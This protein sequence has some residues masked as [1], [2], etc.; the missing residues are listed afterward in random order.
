[1]PPAQPVKAIN[2]TLMWLIRVTV[3]VVCFA[4]GWYGMDWFLTRPRT[5]NSPTS[6]ISFTYPGKWKKVTGTGFGI[7]AAANTSGQ[8][9]AEV[10]LA[11]GNSETNANYYLAVGSS[12]GLTTDFET[13]KSR[14][15]ETDPS[16]LT[17]NMPSGSTV[18]GLT[19]TDTTIA[20]APAVS[21]KYTASFSGYT[22][23]C[24]V[25]FIQSG[26]TLYLLAFRAKKPKGTGE[27]FQELLRTVK[28]KT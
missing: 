12:K 20:G 9:T 23:D 18:T 21:M 7:A 22:S 8:M 16:V 1:M 11:D 15:R 17:A 24:D 19:F 13:I 6:A 2:P 10:E 5:F 27:K 4:I 26:N 25:T 3:V 14:L 28:F